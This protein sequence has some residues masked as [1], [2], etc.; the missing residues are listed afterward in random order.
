[1]L[2][3]N[4]R[5]RRSHEMLWCQLM[6]LGWCSGGRLRSKGSKEFPEVGALGV[7]IKSVT[8][9]FPKIDAK[10]FAADVEVDPADIAAEVIPNKHCSVANREG[11]IEA[12]TAP[13]GAGAIRP[14][15]LRFY[16]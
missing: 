10:S 3:R 11:G 13:C 12:A 4:G 2:L 1:M 6:C 9:T 15:D 5:L 16:C 8:E 7:S 14:P